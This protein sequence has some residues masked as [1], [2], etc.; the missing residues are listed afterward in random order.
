MVAVRAR[1]SE[2]TP[3]RTDSCVLLPVVAGPRRSRRHRR[4]ARPPG[5]GAGPLVEGGDDRTDPAG[6]ARL[7]A[8]SYQQRILERADAG[9][10][11]RPRFQTRVCGDPLADHHRTG[12]GQAST[13]ARSRPP[14]GRL[15]NGVA[16]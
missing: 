3:C 7:A 1:P 11:R 6:T 2:W 15:V 16:L 12:E 5:P 14:L 8:Y 13:N 10:Q 9:H 4:A